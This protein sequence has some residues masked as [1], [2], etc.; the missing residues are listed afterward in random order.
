M[1]SN[2]S[3]KVQVVIDKQ[4]WEESDRMMLQN[5]EMLL[6]LRI[7][8]LDQCA[9]RWMSRVG[10][11]KPTMTARERADFNQQQSAAIARAIHCYERAHRPT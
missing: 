9:R 3:T 7:S 10:L 6:H 2:E 8:P 5:G 1:K 4:V 11:P